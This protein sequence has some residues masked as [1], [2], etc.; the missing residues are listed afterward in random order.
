MPMDTN[1]S[2]VRVRRATVDDV[3]ALVHQRV[4]MYRDMGELPESKAQEFTNAAAGYFRA[5]IASGEYVA[6]LAVTGE[7]QEEVIAGAGLIVLPMIPR[8]APDG[9]I[10]VRE[11]TVVNVYTA[12]AWRRKGLGALV[13]K[14]VLHY[15]R[16]NQINRLSLH[17][18]DDGRP[19]YELLGF[20]P[21]NE[22]RLAR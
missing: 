19:L 16:E 1:R 6:W 12:P 3:A 17:A 8:P 11:G 22:M 13:M 10:E 20:A 15:A 14:R 18:S 21:T 4:S 5:A 9:S 2:D 7:V